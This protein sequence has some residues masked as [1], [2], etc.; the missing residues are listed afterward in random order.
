M[1]LLIGVLWDMRPSNN[2]EDQG[3]Q[4]PNHKISGH[5]N[6][7]LSFKTLHLE[8]D[9]LVHTCNII[10]KGIKAGRSLV[11]GQLGP[12]TEFK[13]NLGFIVRT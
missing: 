7:K 13:T 11:V 5:I 12:Q 8:L 3:F 9:I 6:H 1:V 10:R 4:I 2:L